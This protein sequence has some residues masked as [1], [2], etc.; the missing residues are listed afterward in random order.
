MGNTNEIVKCEY[1][2]IVLKY[3]QC[4]SNYTYFPRPVTAQVEMAFCHS[5][6]LLLCKW[7][8]GLEEGIYGTR[9]LRSCA[10]VYQ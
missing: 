5:R 3:C 1:L 9:P 4:L 6:L 2:K 7:L 8:D 10:C